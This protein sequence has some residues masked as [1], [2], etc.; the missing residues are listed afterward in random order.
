MLM[1][2]RG[3]G[4]SDAVKSR[5][6]LGIGQLIAGRRGDEDAPL[7]RRAS[8]ASRPLRTGG[9]V[10]RR[11]RSTSATGAACDEGRVGAGARAGGEAGRDARRPADAVG[12]IGRW[13]LTGSSLPVSG[14]HTLEHV[15]ERSMSASNDRC[16][17]FARRLAD[18]VQ[19]G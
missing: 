6:S 8:R 2:R 14:A 12:G 10:S 4:G 1:E 17:R 19:I 18:Y 7:I 11:G 5:S 3:D 15:H 13:N 9:G 16:G